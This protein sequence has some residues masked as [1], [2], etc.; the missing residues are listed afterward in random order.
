M[1][2][3]MRL[4]ATAGLAALLA[5]CGVKGP[6]EVPQNAGPEWTRERASFHG[7]GYVGTD[8]ARVAVEA[9]P[10]AYFPQPEPDRRPASVLPYGVPQE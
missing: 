10:P 2:F 6:P 4:L 1:S 8:D 5:G 3:T 9:P 7:G